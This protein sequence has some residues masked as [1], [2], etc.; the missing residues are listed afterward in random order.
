MVEESTSYQPRPIERRKVRFDKIA[1]GADA[2]RAESRSLLSLFRLW[3]GQPTP[4]RRRTPRH[5]V[6]ESQV[7]LGW[8][9]GAAGFLASSAVIINLSRGGAFIFLDERPPKDEPVWVCLGMPDPVGFVEARVVAIKTS[10]QGQCAVRLEFREPCPYGFFEAAVCG[11]PAA[12]PRGRRRAAG[13]G[14]EG[15]PAPRS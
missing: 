12:D 3:D 1:P 5:E 2:P 4:E 6:V 14:S 10:R 11:L 9:R 15:A 7:W 8:W 13:A